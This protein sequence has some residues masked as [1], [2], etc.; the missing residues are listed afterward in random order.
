ML[1][2]KADKLRKAFEALNAKWESYGGPGCYADLEYVDEEDE[3]EREP[4]G[5][6]YLIEDLD[7]RYGVSYALQEIKKGIDALPFPLTVTSGEP[8]KRPVIPKHTLIVVLYDF[9]LTACGC[10]GKEAEVRTAKVGN[11]FW[12]WNLSFREKFQ[13]RN[14]NKGCD[15]VCKA[16]ERHRPSRS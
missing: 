7:E 15:A 5:N 4:S 6:V 14:K 13:G 16:V 10:T 3:D 11:T 2:S 8:V 1:G 9:F 12:Q